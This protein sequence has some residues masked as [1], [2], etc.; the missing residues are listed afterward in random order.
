MSVNGWTLSGP[1]SA[2]VHAIPTP[3][4]LGGHGQALCGKRPST[5]TGWVEREWDQPRVECRDC[6]K[7]A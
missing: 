5:K 7:L 1:R 4:D 3:T 2:R 6:A